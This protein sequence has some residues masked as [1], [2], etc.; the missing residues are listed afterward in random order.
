MSRLAALALFLQLS[1]AAGPAAGTAADFARALRENA[2]DRGECYRVRDLSL[3][4]EDVRIYLTDGHLIFSKPVA[5]HRI[6]AVFT[7]DTEGGDGEVII[8][9]PDRAERRSLAAFTHSPNLDDHFR[10]A[11]FLFT[12]AE[13]DDLQSQIAENSTNK[14]MPEIGALMD[15]QWTPVLRNLTE[16]YETRLVLDLM[17]GSAR[18]TDL[19]AAV[20]DSPKLGTFDVIYD[21]QGSEQVIGGQIASRDNR[22]YFDNWFSFTARSFRK[23]PTPRALD[24]V[25]S[26]Y[27][28]DATIDPDLSMSVVTR[29]KIRAPEGGMAAAAFEITPAMT[30]TGVTVDSRPAETLQPES[31]RSNL[32]RAG[33]KMFLVVPPEPLQQGRDYEFEFHHSGKVVID[34]GDRVFYVAARGN[35]YPMH[36][37]Q[38]AS[39]DL[40]FRYPRDLDLVAPGDVVDDHTEGDWRIAHRR[41]S[42][43]IRMAGFNLGD[44]AHARTER[45]AYTIDIC[46]NRKLEAALQPHATAPLPATTGLTRRRAMMGPLDQNTPPAPAVNPLAKLQTLADQVASALEFM[47]SKFGP[48]A[49][50]H[51]TVTPIPGTF[52]QGFPG[53]I[54]LSTLSYLKDRPAGN[55]ATP[56]LDLFFDDVLQAHETAHQWW[57]NR[58]TTE[59]YRDSWLMEALANYSALLYLEKRRGSRAVDQ[60]LGEYRSALLEKNQDGETVES[61]GPIVLGQRLQSSLQP[62]GWR[63]ITYGKGS[64]I[65]HM[66]RHRMGDQRFLAMLGDIVKRYDHAS[67]TTEQFRKSAAQFLPPKSEDPTLV[68]FFD[69]WVYGTGIPTLKLTYVVKGQAPAL[70]LVGTLDQSGVDEDFSVLTPVEIQIARGQSITRWIASSNQPVTF[71]VALKQTPLKV[72]LDPHNAVL[73]R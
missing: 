41:V 24:L 8:F 39:Y 62:A 55:L 19:L 5:G 23:N 40:K 7:A 1:I 59:N 3:V 27:R 48:P 50:P 73:R 21:P 38:F 45:G 29:V 57:G 35:W 69:Q 37:L 14:K 16:S 31:L 4:K 13:Y 49:L 28:I 63:A 32:L 54:Y 9:P 67:I 10:S 42:A 18:P 72:A 15:E 26:D 65:L 61:A 30:I 20:F 46:A 60:M 34:A 47:A 33:N 58:V 22:T 51:L 64:W 25:T 36:G 6:A 2:F 12:G 44:Y 70:R 56:S 66:L 17:G 52:G 43:T 11:L 71:T 68:G 53:L